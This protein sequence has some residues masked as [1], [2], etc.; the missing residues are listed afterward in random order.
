MYATNNRYEISK[1]KS[2]QLEEEKTW[3]CVFFSKTMN[4]NSIEILQQY[5][6]PT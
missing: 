5:D 1:L 4:S 2:I 3:Y 6:Q